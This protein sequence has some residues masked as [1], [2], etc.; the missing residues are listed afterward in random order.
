MDDELKEQL[1]LDA[2][3]TVADSKHLGQ[4]LDEEKPEGVENESVEQIAFADKILLNKTDLVSEDEKAALVTKIKAI[5]SRAKIIESV[6]S[7][8]DMNEIIGIKAFDLDQVVEMDEEFLNVDGEHQH[9]DSVTSVGIKI[10]G[11]LDLEKLNGWL[12]GLLREKGQDIFRSKGIIAIKGSDDRY[13][14][15]GVHML[16]GMASSVEGKFEG[17]KEGQERLNR[18]IFIGKNLNREELEAG[19][20]ACIVK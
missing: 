5:N 18:F 16:M 11:E 7:K 10:A 4:H 20:K 19:F 8:V 12:S 6:Q 2:I 13:V 14:F 9:D 17:W 3:L 1:Y 15:Q